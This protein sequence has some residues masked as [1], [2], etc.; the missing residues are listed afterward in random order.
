MPCPSSATDPG[1]S[2]LHE[3]L[4]TPTSK[5]ET[6]TLPTSP[7]SVALASVS[8]HYSP[9]IVIPCRNNF[10]L[11]KGI[12]FSEDDEIDWSDSWTK[13]PILSHFSHLGRPSFNSVFSVS[14]AFSLASIYPRMR[15]REGTSSSRFLPLHLVSSQH[16][17][18][19]ELSKLTNCL[20][21]SSLNIFDTQT[22]DQRLASPLTHKNIIRNRGS[23]QQSVHSKHSA[24]VLS[25]ELVKKSLWPRMHG[26][27]SSA[28]G[29][30]KKQYCD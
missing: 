1:L 10:Q 30:R 14:L 28:V 19:E 4:T 11:S 9:T 5:D 27:A 24:V 13:S 20:V 25:T 21:K 7:S 2:P 29:A 16:S 15:L 8:T 17:A 22:T 23:E 18:E 26:N 6:S 3:A 12:V